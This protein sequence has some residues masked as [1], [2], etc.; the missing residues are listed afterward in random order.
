MFDKCFEELDV[1]ETEGRPPP[2][3]ALVYYILYIIYYILYGVH[4]H[5]P[6]CNLI[7]PHLAS[8]G[9]Q[10]LIFKHPAL[11]TALLRC[12]QQWSVSNNHLHASPLLVSITL[13]KITHVSTH[14]DHIRRA[15][16]KPYEMAGIK[17]A[18]S[19][20]DG[21]G[22]IVDLTNNATTIYIM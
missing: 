16:G 21:T 22:Y 11:G 3:H 8:I 2:E 17:G 15:I 12:A 13:S 9:H 6:Y 19:S 4:L 1:I 20:Y 10:Y 5:Q 18:I 14:H 7:V